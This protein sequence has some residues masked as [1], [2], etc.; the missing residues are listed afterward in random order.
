MPHG[1]PEQPDQGDGVTDDLRT[2]VLRTERLT[3]TTWLPDDL[4]DLHRLH[5]DPVTMTFIGGRP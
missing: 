4:G 5:G 1:R 3:L 2:V